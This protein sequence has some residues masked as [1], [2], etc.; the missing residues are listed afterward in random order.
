M[1]NILNFG[2][3]HFISMATPQYTRAAFTNTKNANLS[4]K[5]H[6]SS[7][8][9]M[10]ITPFQNNDSI[11][12]LNSLSNTVG[13]LPQINNCVRAFPFTTVTTRRSFIWLGYLFR[14]CSYTWIVPRMVGPGAEMYSH[15][16]LLL[17][18]V[19]AVFDNCNTKNARIDD[20]LRRHCGVQPV[21]RPLR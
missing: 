14:T 16:R 8:I 7:C 11:L 1:H 19:Y 15:A 20:W 21:R 9:R 18:N 12:T 17:V 3:K 6:L 2:Y 13:R 10:A 4:L 5:C